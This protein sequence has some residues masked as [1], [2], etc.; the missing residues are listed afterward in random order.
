MTNPTDPRRVPGDQNFFALGAM[1]PK[2]PPKF[3]FFKSS[4]FGFYQYQHHL[5]SYFGVMTH[6]TN[7]NG[8]PGDQKF[9]ALG[10]MEPQKPTQFIFFNLQNTAFSNIS[11]T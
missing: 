7:P 1:E 3:N 9:F 4:K 5:K 11:T 2:K 8:V 6:P 10:A